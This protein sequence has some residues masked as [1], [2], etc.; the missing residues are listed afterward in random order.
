M[1]DEPKVVCKEVCVITLVWLEHRVG[2][3]PDGNLQKVAKCLSRLSLNSPLMSTVIFPWSV[4][5]FK[6]SLTFSHSAGIL[7]RV[8]RTGICLSPAR[9]MGHPLL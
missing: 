2:R 7:S 1:R 6:S 9:T 5:D 4:P 8:V 3:R